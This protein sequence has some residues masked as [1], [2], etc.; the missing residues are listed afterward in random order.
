MSHTFGPINSRRFGISLGI[1]LSTDI[2]RC[3]FDCLYCELESSNVVNSHENPA[4]VDDVIKDV[5]KALEKFNHIDV[6]TITSNGEP[7]LYPYLDDLVDRLNSIKKEKKTLILSNASLINQKHIQKILS[8]IDIVKLSLDSVNEKSFKKIDRQHSDIKLSSIKEGIKEFAKYNSKK[9][10][11]E[12]L[13]VKDINDSDK[14]IEE[15]IAFLN[16]ITPS[17]VDIGTIDRPPA[18]KVEPILNDKLLQIAKKMDGL[19]VSIAFKKNDKL[20]KIN[21]SEDE[22][23]SFAKRRPISQADLEQLF[24]QN[25]RKILENLVENRVLLQKNQNGV[26]FYKYKE[27]SFG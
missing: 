11:I 13:F 18:Y 6:I 25:S 10:V 20:K 15:L 21:Y 17:R 2:K 26:N 8:K 5:Q 7:T 23:I 27:L 1:D 19:N 22:I 9:L 14:D 3:N 16:Q 12:V 4:L 24:T